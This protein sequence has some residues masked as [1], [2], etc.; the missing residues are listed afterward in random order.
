MRRRLR[1]RLRFVSQRAPST[2]VGSVSRRGRWQTSAFERF[3]RL[4]TVTGERETQARWGR[5][6][7]GA[8]EEAL[9]SAKEL[10]VRVR[11][12]G[13][14]GAEYSACRGRVA[15]DED[16]ARPRA[17]VG[18]FF[19]VVVEGGQGGTIAIETVSETPVLDELEAR[20]NEEADLL[21][22]YAG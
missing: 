6:Y 8:P 20:W 9:A 5:Q 13:H 15:N 16:V 18:E 22:Q 3:L 19:T 10:G 7:T 12:V 1:S 17:T 2:G 21:G 4:G 14:V 11:R